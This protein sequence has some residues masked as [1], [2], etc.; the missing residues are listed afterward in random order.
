MSHDTSRGPPSLALRLLAM[1]IPEPDGEYLIGDLVEAFHARCAR[2]GERNARRWFWTETVH[3]LVSRW[4]SPAF[5]P[6]NCPEEEPM[7]TIVQSMRIAARSLVRSPALTA[8]VIVTLALG[9]GATT[10]VYSVA[11]AALFAKLPYPD[12]DQLVTVWE[13]E[14]EGGDSNVGFFTF[15][16]LARESRVFA[17]AAAMSY[18]T[19]TISNG[20]ETTRLTGQRVSWTF[21]DVLGMKPMLGRGFVE[22]EDR[23]GATRV[24]VLSHKLWNTRFGAD[25]SIVGRDIQVNGSAFRV[26]GVLPPTFESVLWPGAEIWA[27]LGYDATLPYSCRSCRHLRMVARLRDQ[28]TPRSA[29]EHLDRV[30]ARLKEGFPNE[31]AG[32]GLS[33]VPV[34]EFVVR[35]SRP[36]MLALLGAVGLVAL[37]ACFNAA[38]LLLSRAL[39]R[40]SEFAIRIALGASRGRLATLLL[41]EGL[42]ISL[43]AASLGAVLAML[44]V[45]V[46][47][48]MAPD[49]IPRLDQVRID[50]GVLVFAVTLALITGLAASV[51]PAWSLLRQGL[52]D[53]IRSGARSLVGLGRHRL[54][55]ALV[56]VEVALAVMLVSGTA[57]LLGSV[58]RLLSV[59]T[60][61]ETASRLTM[62]LDL[63]GAYYA[64]SG[65]AEQTWRTV[66]DGVHSVPGVRAAALASQIPLGG[67]VDM[68]GMHVA[69]GNPAEDPSA[70]RYAVTPRYFE[71]MKIELVAGR[72]FTA[73]DVLGAPEVVVLNEAAANRLFPSGTAVGRQVQVG[74]SRPVST[75]VGI[76]GNTLHRGL[77]RE[78]EM[79]V[80]LPSSQWGEEGGMTLVL[81]TNVPPASVTP[82]IRNA[83]RQAGPG[84]AITKVATFER[85]VDLVT[86]D[87]RFALALFAGFAVV[88]LVLATAGLYGVLSA[89]VVERTREIGVRT[90]L[91][92]QRGSIL[93][94]VVRQ[95]MLLAGLGLV[96]GL[97]ATWGSTKI[98][99]TLL[100][101]VGASDPV[102]LVAVVG[103][104]GAAALLAC[105]LPAWRAS[106][107]DPVIALRGS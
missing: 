43:A 3:V 64:D 20:Q 95:G 93:A 15:E 41:S 32:T 12:S 6:G 48:G 62:E 5:R 65:R 72:L 22:E 70:M 28:S 85:L 94:M 45:D 103:T 104:L 29:T 73:S 99:S 13:R 87:R 69:G 91:G 2:D 75:V 88:A 39:R 96:V 98:I 63:S 30:Y 1:R 92:A 26:A 97:F 58:S 8:L 52:N 35:Q 71:T 31:Y 47:V 101:G 84:I 44:G 17:S 74:G 50:G 100:F 102:V 14:K 90:A 42:F 33:L 7:D 105:A 25:S 37:I 34:H 80:Y 107:V 68:Y 106:R 27:P 19:P 60:G 24:V 23:R 38:N 55:G 51:L 56:A 86:A 89:T 78:E 61:F 49:G 83:V 79:Q 4:P 82:A 77:D 11:R 10:S 57:A 18:W 59:D 53:G 9:I 21:F 76:V 67:N 54:R 16:D 40:E 46:L 36:A 81:H 66:L